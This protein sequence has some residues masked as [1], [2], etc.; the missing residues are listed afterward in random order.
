[1][2][3]TIKSRKTGETITISRPGS[4][5]YLYV[6]FDG[7]KPGTLGYQACTGGELS[8]NTIACNED[9]FQRVA[10][11]WYRAYIRKHGGEL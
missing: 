3:L 2:E 8:G 1:M 4:Y 11:N 10:R 5:G 6:D 7:T 9:N